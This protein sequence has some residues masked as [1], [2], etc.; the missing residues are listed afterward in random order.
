MVT[1]ATPTETRQWILDNAPTGEVVTSGPDQTFSL[2]T[3]PLPILKSNQVL[4]KNLY[5]SND[6]AQRPWIQKDQ[7]P[8]RLYMPPVLPGD[9]MQSR[10]IAE[11]IAS[12]ADAFPVGAHCLAGTGW[13]EYRVIDASQCQP[14]SLVPGLKETHFLGALGLTGLTAYY[15]LKTIGKVGPGETLVVSGAAGATGSMAVQIAKKMLGCKRVI[16]LAGS[17]DKCRWVE[18]LGADVCI[19]YKRE[20]VWERLAAETEGYVEAF[21]DNVAGQ[22]LDFMLSRLK[23]HGRVISCGAIDVYNKEDK[24]QLKNYHEIIYNRLEIRGFI[25]IDLLESGGAPQA[26]ADL[27]QAYQEGKIRIGDESETVVDTKIE[28]IPKT[29]LKLFEGGNT[30]KLVTK[31]V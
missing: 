11:V 3:N 6:P 23:R 19:N 7:D 24:A 18:S 29:W 12:T 1:T 13:S 15:G 20:D 27:V 17:D 22:T 14:I 28:D 9:V 4:L 2:R 16:G 21:F 30:G 26:I 25:V 5:L 10:G 8:K 31:I